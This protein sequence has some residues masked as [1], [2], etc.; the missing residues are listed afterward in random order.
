[1]IVCLLRHGNAEDFAVGGD[2]A[3]AL[4]A[5]G[6]QKLEH[7]ARGWAK[8]VEGAERIYASPLLRAQQTAAVFQRAVAPHSP[9]LTAPDLVPEARPLRALE[10]IQ[11]AQHDGLKSMCCVGHEPH[12]GALLGL[13]LT[14]S[15]R[16]AIPFKKGM[17]A[18]VDMDSSASLIGRL[19]CALS[20]RIAGKL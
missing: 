5:D 17:L 1:V 10:R 11:Q 13:L 12:M 20:Q 16:C 19:V 9:I 15:E 7:A 2:A 8:V 18:V 4:T 3:R 6:L 14:G